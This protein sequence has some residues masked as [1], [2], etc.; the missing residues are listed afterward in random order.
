MLCS[1][2]VRC[3]GSK[4][5]CSRMCKQILHSIRACAFEGGGVVAFGVE[6]D[7]SSR[8]AMGTVTL[9]PCWRGPPAQCDAVT[10]TCEFLNFFFHL[11]FIPISNCWQTL[12]HF[13]HCFS[14]RSPHWHFVLCGGPR[15]RFHCG[16]CA[17]CPSAISAR[18][19][20]GSQA[21][22]FPC[23]FRTWVDAAGPGAGNSRYV[24]GFRSSL[25][26]FIQYL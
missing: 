15:Y 24:W 9:D 3:S 6:S 26:L 1:L 18:E 12:Y 10:T 22:V 17:G 13:L 7:M 25:I 19:T 23:S 5:W 8:W 21:L 14:T 16:C 20:C 4:P 11:K 2:T